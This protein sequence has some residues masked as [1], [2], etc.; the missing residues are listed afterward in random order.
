MGFRDCVLFGGVGESVGVGFG[1]YEF[2]AFAVDVDD[3]DGW[4]VLEVLAEFGDVD[5]H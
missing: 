2:V 1:G 4:I 3:F 5:V